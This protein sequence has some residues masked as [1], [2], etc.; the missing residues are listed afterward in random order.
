[1]FVTFII[2]IIARGFGNL[3]RYSCLYHGS[4]HPRI[5]FSDFPLQNSDFL[6]LRITFERQVGNVTKLKI[7][8]PVQ[9]FYWVRSLKIVAL[10]IYYH[11]KPLLMLEHVSHD[12]TKNKVLARYQVRSQLFC[13]KLC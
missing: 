12:V 1:M 8:L 4:L 9:F 3:S 2:L 11:F 5:F 7:V 6:S 10:V 13:M